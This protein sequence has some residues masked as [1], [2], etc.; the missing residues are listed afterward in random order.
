M[1][2]VSNYFNASLVRFEAGVKLLT[3]VLF[4][5]GILR[6]LLCLY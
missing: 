2:L 3:N 6:T 4:L 1:L 5:L